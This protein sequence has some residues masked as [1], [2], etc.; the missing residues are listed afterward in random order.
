MS[1]STRSLSSLR[2]WQWLLSAERALTSIISYLLPPEA[3]CLL[4]YALEAE[5]EPLQPTVWHKWSSVFYAC[6]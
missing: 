6:N 1:R 3:V 4:V 5:Y 2:Y